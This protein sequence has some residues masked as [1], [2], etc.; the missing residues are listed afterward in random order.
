MSCK[1]GLSD[2]IINRE[3]SL[4]WNKSLGDRFIPQ[5][6]SLSSTNFT[7]MTVKELL[8]SDDEETPMSKYHDILRA[9]LSNAETFKEKSKLFIYNNKESKKMVPETI[10][11]KKLKIKNKRRS[12]FELPNGPYK[13]L[14]AP[15]IEDDYYLSLLDWSSK[16]QLAVSLANR[17]YIL[18][19]VSQKMEKLYEAFECEA[20]CSV[21]WNQEGTQ[22]AVG[23]LLGQLSIWDI[24]KG[25]EVQSY[26]NHVD[27]IASI[28]WKSTL[29][30]GSK[31]SE[32]S[33]IDPRT[34]FVVNKFQSHDEEVCKVLWSLDENSFA[35]GGNDNKMCVWSIGKN[36]PLMKESH[37]GSI[38]ALGWSSKQYGILAS[39]G[40]ANDNSIYIWNTNTKEM[41]HTRDTSSQVCSLVFSSIT[42]DVITSHSGPNNEVNI[43]RTKGLKKVG[44]LVGHTERVLY[45]ALSPCGTSL[46]TGSPDETIRFWK[47]YND[48]EEGEVRRNST[49]SIASLIR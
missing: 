4:S 48:S 19:V 24:E 6:I 21:K 2:Q 41:V 34:R 5:R 26:E 25:V 13:V 44:T 11:P 10:E 16:N 39:G 17:I 14:E 46:L 37:K 8:D 45:T 30:V 27:R 43:W 49:I 29:L 33:Q 42:N 47:L 23:N 22:L 9:N 18:D 12:K 32:I 7:M 40:G 1:A 3:K 36:M 31:D 15:C 38:K 20:L 28:D 35:S